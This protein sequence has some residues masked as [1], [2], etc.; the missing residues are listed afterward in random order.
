MIENIGSVSIFVSDQERAKRFY[1]EVLGCKLKQ[2]TPVRPGSDA[3]WIAV[4]PASGGTEIVLYKP[5]ETWRH[6]EHVIGKPQALTLNVRN[7]DEVH[8]KLREKGV[9]F[10]HEPEK[11]SW[12]VYAIIHDSEGNQLMLVEKATGS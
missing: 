3:R 1:T 4:V 8:T 5:D 12:G 7:M 9:S 6:Y 10:V 2:D 11:E